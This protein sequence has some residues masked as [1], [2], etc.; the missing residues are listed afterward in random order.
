[1]IHVVRDP[2]KVIQSFLNHILFFREDRI[3]D[4]HSP[5]WFIR[6]HLPH[7]DLLPDAESRACYFYLRWNQWIEEAIDGRRYLLHR[8]EDGPQALADFLGAAP[9]QEIADDT[10]CNAYDQWPDH[11]R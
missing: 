11:M 4:P 2:L 9:G 1:I 5:E 10:T 3:T 8:I 7:L 6:K